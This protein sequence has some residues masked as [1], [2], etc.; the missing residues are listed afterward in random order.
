VSFAGR[1]RVETGR[2]RCRVACAGRS[3]W[4]AQG[5]VTTGNGGGVKETSARA[6]GRHGRCN[7]IAEKFHRHKGG[8]RNERCRQR[9]RAV[10][11]GHH[12]GCD[13]RRLDGCAGTVI[14]TDGPAPNRPEPR[15]SLCERLCRRAASGRG[16]AA[17]NENRPRLAV[18]SL[19]TTGGSEA[20]SRGRRR[21]PPRAEVCPRNDEK[22]V[23]GCGGAGGA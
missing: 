8:A 15:S 5:R 21:A 17:G 9:V 16:D 12:G 7:F 22:A 4:C 11:R 19:H 18:Y 10:D 20:D 13:A 3:R 14:D 23:R 2:A 1:R 6:A